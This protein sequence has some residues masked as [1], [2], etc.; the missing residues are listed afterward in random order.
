[1]IGRVRKTICR[2]RLLMDILMNIE[3]TLKPKLTKDEA[4]K[5]HR[6]GLNK[7]LRIR[8]ANSVFAA[9]LTVTGLTC[10]Y[11]FPEQVQFSELILATAAL[12]VALPVFYEGAKG[13]F[14]RQPK[15]MT[16]QLVSLAILASML[17]G[18]FITAALIPIIMVAGH[19]L[20]EKGIIGVGEAIAAMKKLHNTKARLVE[21][22]HEKFVEA[23]DLKVGEIIACYPG[24]TIAADGIVTEGESF[25]NQAPITGE[26]V[27][28]DVYGGINVFA[29]TINISGKIFIKVT[30]L[31]ADTVFNKI[32]ALLEEA[33]S[34]KAPIVKIIE[35]YLDLYFPFVIMVAA[36]TL[37]MSGDVERAVAVI[38]ISCPCALVLA[39]PTAMIAALVRASKYGIM[40]K[41]TA[42][43]EVLSE[44][45]TVIFDKTGTV[46]LGH[47]EVEKIEPEEG[48]EEDKVVEIAGICACGSIHPVSAAIVSYLH[49]KKIKI[50]VSKYQKEY[51]GQGVEASNESS[52]SYIGKLSWI[53]EKIGF[54]AGTTLGD[55]DKI[56]TWVSDGKRILGRILFSDRPRPEM[57]ETI[58][59]IKAKGI[60][61]V[62]LLTGDKKEIADIVGDFLN[63]DE[64]VAECLPQDKLNYVNTKKCCGHKVMFVGDGVN[65]ALALKA[66]DVGVAVA[67]GGSDIAVQ[68]SDI[69]LSSEN[70]E[71]IVK[72][73]ELSDITKNIITQN[74]LIG[75]GFSFILLALASMGMVSPVVGAVTHNLGPVFVV[76]NS[77]RL[78]K[79][80]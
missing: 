28:V 50:H 68:N 31:P 19:L 39:S 20:E 78:L 48:I 40:I 75:A 73:F 7:L 76:L 29:G 72:M 38:V 70:L 77:A 23:E 33:E 37:F 32:A 3:T 74:I 27:P 12:S 16:E 59:M 35:Q 62:I 17:Q 71:S 64:T 13:L 4:E 60:S 55:T 26:S 69:T 65:D 47:L 57:K 54:E 14:S 56:T 36:I 22:G 5:N 18:D 51:H 9:V 45:D 52:K 61:E 49:E 15:F 8:L 80:Q 53:R 1:M 2:S 42:F 6:V 25:V 67:R 46:T 10:R 44:V 63:V 66:G 34:S 58:S 21:G 11:F 24:E 41:N 79:K 43:L 30:K